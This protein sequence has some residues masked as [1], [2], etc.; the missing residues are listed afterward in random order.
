MLCSVPKVTVV[1]SEDNP[2]EEPE[3]EV[4]DDPY[5]AKPL[6]AEDVPLAVT[7]TKVP[8]LALPPL[9]LSRLVPDRFEF[10]C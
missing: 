2:D 10:C 3:I 8:L 7:L 4:S 5:E 6:P 1:R 9:V